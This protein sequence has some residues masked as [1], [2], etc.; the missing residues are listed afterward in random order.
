MKTADR[1]TVGPETVEIE[2]M[3]AAISGPA[4]K[5]AFLAEVARVLAVPPFVM[6]DAPS[7]YDSARATRRHW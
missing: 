3:D 4:L 2:P 5:Q 6:N 1:Q 7:N